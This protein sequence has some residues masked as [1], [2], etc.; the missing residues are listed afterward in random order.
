MV[1][2][3]DFMGHGVFGNY[4]PLPLSMKLAIDNMSMMSVAV[5]N[6]IDLHQT[7]ELV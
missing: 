5:L 7:W 4:L 3:L 6:K 2:I 1:S